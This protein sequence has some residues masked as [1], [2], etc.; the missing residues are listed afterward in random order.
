[1]CVHV[2]L[3]HDSP[4][5]AVFVPYRYLCTQL[6][7]GKPQLVTSNWQASNWQTSNWQ[8]LSVGFVKAALQ[9]FAP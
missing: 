8:T 6:Q 3:Y 5:A 2:I 4:L 1:M 9:G 7:T